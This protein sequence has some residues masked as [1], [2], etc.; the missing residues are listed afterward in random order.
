LGG[1]LVFAS[2]VLQVGLELRH[3]LHNAHPASFFNL[4]KRYIYK[5]QM[6]RPSRIFRKV[7]SA[8]LFWEKTW[9]SRQQKQKAASR[10]RDCEKKFALAKPIIYILPRQQNLL[11]FKN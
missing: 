3:P 4:K 10:T 11:S 9:R 8:F 5:E 7:V 6:I 2:K 1:K